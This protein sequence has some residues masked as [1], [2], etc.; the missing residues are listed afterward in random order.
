MLTVVGEIVGSKV[1]TYQRP[2]HRPPGLPPRD[3][4]AH[5]RPEPADDVLR[6][7][8]RHRRWQADRYPRGGGA[9]SSARRVSSATSGSSP[10]RTMVLFGSRP[11]TAT[12]TRA[13]AEAIGGLYPIYPLTKGVESW[14]LQRAVTFARTVVDDV[15]E[16]VPD[17]RAQRPTTLIDAEHGLRLDP[18]PRHVRPGERGRSDTSGSRRRWSPSSCSD[19]GAARCE[20]S[21]RRRATG[22][23]GGVLAAF[24]ARL[25]FSSPP[26]SARSVRRSSTT[27]RGRTR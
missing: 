20:S 7:E 14:D 4:A 24:D 22:A 2:A 6:Q 27:W 8:L 11:P 21:G 5:R 17:G 26:G 1:K 12:R 3:G 10:T 23:S 25:P 13:A 19:A 16:V 9:C 18:R 15:P